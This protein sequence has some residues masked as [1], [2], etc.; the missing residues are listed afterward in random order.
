MIF[1]TFF[2][3]YFLESNMEP[4]P[5]TRQ[6]LIWL[7]MYPP[8]NSTSQW[9]KVT[10]AIYT[11]IC[12]GALLT[13]F[14]GD[15]AFC[16]KFV[17]SNLGRSLFSFMFVVAEF[18]VIYMGFVAIIL[19]QHEIETIFELLSTIYSASKRSNWRNYT[20]NQKIQTFFKIKYKIKSYF[21]HDWL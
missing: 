17:A 11:A 8:D 21:D 15:L 5:M 10:H 19:L 1:K 2:V 9:Q 14:G 18:S 3:W 16:F 6:S 4:L 12:L 20:T 13:C 7:C